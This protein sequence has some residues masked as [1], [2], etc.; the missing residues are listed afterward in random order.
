[1]NANRKRTWWLI[2]GAL[3]ALYFAPS[4]MHSF[5]EASGD[6]ERIALAQA[7][8]TA[9]R[10]AP[11]S[12]TSSVST[13]TPVT[14]AVPPNRLLGVWVGQQG[15]TNMELCRLQLEIRDK[16]EAQVNGYVKMLCYPTGAYYQKHPK[17]NVQ[18]TFMKAMTPMAAILSGTINSGS[19]AFHID[20]T[21]GTGLDGCPLSSFAVTSFGNDEVAA[22][23]Q[24]EGCPGGQMTLSRSSK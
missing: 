19:I 3:L 4:A 15:E 6:Q 10:P 24:K 20:K 5:R 16:G 23:W 7:R 13:P 21:I 22:E 2:G 12:P 1:M 9:A 11:G 17:I 8:A 18:E 14:P